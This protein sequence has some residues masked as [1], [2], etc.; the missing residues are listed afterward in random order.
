MG[1]NVTETSLKAYKSISKE[2][3]GR[4]LAVYNAIKEIEPCNNLMIAKHLNLPINSICGRVNELRN[5]LKLV[6][7][8]HTADCPI[9]GKSTMFW[10]VVG[11][12]L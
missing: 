11:K 8:S 4:Q 6:G 1:N 3:K 9:T 12:I 10:K 5:K 7:Y 2:L